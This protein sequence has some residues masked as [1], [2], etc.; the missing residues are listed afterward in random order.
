MRERPRN[1]HSL[2]ARLRNIARREKIADNRLELLVAKTVLGHF[3]SETGIGTIKGA[4]GIEFRLGTLNTRVSKDLDSIAD[5]NTFRDKL[6][7]AMAKGWSGFSGVLKEAKP[8]NAPVPPDYQ[9]DAFEAKVHYEGRIFRSVSLEVSRSEIDSTSDVDTFLPTEPVAIFQEFG[10]EQPTQLA[11]LGLKHQIAQKLHAC[12]APDEENWKN[13]RARD[14]VDLQ[15]L[16][17]LYA[18]GSL[19]EL[20]VT[21]SR[22]FRSRKRHAWPPRITERDGWEEAYAELAEGLGVVPNL[23]EALELLNDYIDEIE[24]S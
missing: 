12:T 11:L 9:P 3:L 2:R 4:S 8:I 18:G 5:P 19:A 20:K 17:D 13:G 21:C 7:A 14:L 24:A 23:D 1:L 15:L 16:R 22:L 6:E 10:L